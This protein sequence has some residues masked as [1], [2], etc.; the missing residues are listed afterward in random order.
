MEMMAVLA[1]MMAMLMVTLFLQHSTH[2]KVA[3]EAK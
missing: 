1:G 2:R 3:V